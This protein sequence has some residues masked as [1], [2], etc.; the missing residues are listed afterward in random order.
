[1]KF[2]LSKKPVIFLLIYLL[3]FLSISGCTGSRS[4]TFSYQQADFQGSW[5]MVGFGHKGKE[6]FNTL[7]YL[8][9]NDTGTVTGGN[10]VEYGY[11]S[12]IFTGGRLS[13]SQDDTLSGYI[14]TYLPDVGHHDKHDII[15]GKMHK[16]KDII[17]FSGRFPVFHRGL[18][19]LLKKWQ[20]YQQ[21]DLDGMWAF[22][23]NNDTLSVL[24]EP[25]GTISECTISSSNESVI[26]SGALSINAEG[27]IKG[28]I[29]YKIKKDNF[30]ISFDGQINK[31]K[32]I[33]IFAGSISTGF[34][35]IA[36]FAIKKDYNPSLTD[37]R[38]SWIIYMTANGDA[39]F[40]RITI[41]DGGLI[42]SG[43]L[44]L[45]SG[46]SIDINGELLTHKDSITGFLKNNADDNTIFLKGHINKEKDFGGGF[47]KDR[48]TNSGIFIIIRDFRF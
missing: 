36:T 11:D 16:E 12:K 27:A 43:I 31:N 32:D 25:S 28:Q 18:G 35:G 47:Y 6:P 3:V 22:P 4:T 20:N 30:E 40:G 8:I 21:S 46:G 29:E 34:E 23:I 48:L 41:N 19:I 2:N 10:T 15:S 5:T 1:M 13:F 38:G 17:V 37:T 26:C 7:G 33:M 39:I 24:I 14:N 9:I 44:N 45:L 42:T